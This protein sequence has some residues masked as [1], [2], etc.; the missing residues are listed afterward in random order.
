[1]ML[2][3]PEPRSFRERFCK[4]YGIA[5]GDF[6][7]AALERWLHPPWSSLA[8]LLLRV[9]PSFFAT[10]LDVVRQIGRVAST[11][12]LSAEVRGIRNE[13]QRRR[14]FGLTRRLLRRRLSSGRIFAS[15]KSCWG[16]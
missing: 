16:V 3:M 11:N 7:M 2:G 14:D 9:F 8:A 5:D 4:H 1:M 10:D 6:D 12:N 13:Y 15:A